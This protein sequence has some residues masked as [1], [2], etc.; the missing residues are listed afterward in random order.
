VALE[1]AQAWQVEAQEVALVGTHIWAPSRV[2]CPF[3]VGLIFDDAVYFLCLCLFAIA[4]LGNRLNPD[5]CTDMLHHRLELLSL[6]CPVASGDD[7][8]CLFSS[9][10]VHYA[11]DGGEWQHYHDD[12]ALLVDLAY[13]AARVVYAALLTLFFCGVMDALGHLWAYQHAAY[14]NLACFHSMIPAG[15][16]LHCRLGTSLLWSISHHY[17]IHQTQQ[18]QFFVLPGAKKTPRAT[19]PVAACPFQGMES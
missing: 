3:V 10:V 5:V 15:E 14:E 19:W 9:V 11:F 18:H 17:H 12:V 16:G 6:Q 7:V 8:R 2:Y 13:Q 1:Q 4:K